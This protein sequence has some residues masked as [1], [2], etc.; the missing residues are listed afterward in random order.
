MP[1]IFKFVDR[2]GKTQWM[3]NPGDC[4]E[5]FDGID[6]SSTILGPFHR[7]N[8]HAANIPN[9]SARMVKRSIQERID[10]PVGFLKLNY[11]I[12]PSKVGLRY[13]KH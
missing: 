8:R 6:G 10:E 2:D 1:D 5:I 3:F 11:Q 12:T 13:H 9:V 7:G 4:I